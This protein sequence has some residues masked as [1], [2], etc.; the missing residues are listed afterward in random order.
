VSFLELLQHDC[1]FSLLLDLVGGWACFVVS[2]LWIGMLTAVIGDTASA[3]GCTIGL[4][5]SVT[6]ISFVALG[7]SVP[8]RGVIYRTTDFY[9]RRYTSNILVSVSQRTSP[10][11]SRVN[12]YSDT[13]EKNF[14]NWNMHKLDISSSTSR[15]FTRHIMIMILH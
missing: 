15:K 1:L 10:L 7:T 13:F 2:I 14:Q 9:C 5:D 8:G 6:A 12:V 3:F 11:S 4:L